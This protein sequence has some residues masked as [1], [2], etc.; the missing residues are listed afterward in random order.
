MV[1]ITVLVHGIFIVITIKH[2]INGGYVIYNSSEHQPYTLH[3]SHRRSSYRPTLHPKKWGKKINKNEGAWW[4]A[5]SNSLKVVEHKS[6]Q[7]KIFYQNVS[8]C[9]R[10]RPCFHIFLTVPYRFK[11]L[12]NACIRYIIVFNYFSEV[13]NRFLYR[14][15]AC[16]RCTWFSSIS[17]QFQVVSDTTRMH[18]LETLYMCKK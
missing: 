6:L 14:H 12:K 10:K 8:Y 1:Y 11:Y 4:V 16:F 2:L 7:V 9:T 5:L 15:N 17:L 18:T 3:K 13:L